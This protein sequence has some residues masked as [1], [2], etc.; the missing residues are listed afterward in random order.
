VT[1]L[2][3]ERVVAD[4]AP[5]AREAGARMEPPAEGSGPGVAWREALVDEADQ[6]WR[7]QAREALLVLL[8]LGLYRCWVRTRLRQ[9]IWSSVTIDGRPLAYTGTVRDLLVPALAA[10]SGLLAVVIAVIVI[11]MLAVPRPRLTPSPWRLLVTIPLVYMLGLA[12][13]RHRGFL[14][15]RTCLAGRE[16]RL[17]GGRHAFAAIHLLTMLAMPLTLGWVMPWRQV[18]LQRRLIEGMGIGPHRFTFEGSARRL[19]GRFAVAWAGVIAVYL[20]AVLMV[21]F[22]MG[23]KII[24]ARDAGTW[25]A[26]DGR[27]LLIAVAIG[28]AAAVAIGLLCAWYRIGVWRAL[29]AATRLDGRPLRLEAATGEYLALVIGNT[30]LR[31]GSLLLL[32]P[33]ADLRHARFL[34]SRLRC[35]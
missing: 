28:F 13:W 17:D 3:I 7:R 35:A 11:K 8:T 12:A 29:V 2:L 6:D 16:G 24:A 20:G 31:A 14:L 32:S 22:T 5:A 18:A 10:L 1:T 33:A 27:E 15:A 19:L 26:L 9:R 23:P 4:R 30:L 34:L 25:P 21:A